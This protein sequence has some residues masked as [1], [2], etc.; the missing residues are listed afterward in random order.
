MFILDSNIVVAFYNVIE[1]MLVSLLTSN[2]LIQTFIKLPKM[3]EIASV[4]LLFEMFLFFLFNDY[5]WYH[6]EKKSSQFVSPGQNN[7]YSYPCKCYKNLRSGKHLTRA[8]PK[9]AEASECA[10]SLGIFIF[11]WN[12]PCHWVRHW[13]E[14]NGRER[15]AQD[16]AE[17]V[18]PLSCKGFSFHSSRILKRLTKNAV[19]R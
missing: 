12:H 1:S 10:Q 5:F 19:V 16:A 15:R 7:F 14:R 6:L 4:L 9:K 18:A 11:K 8:P 17:I 3:I 13:E 2:Q